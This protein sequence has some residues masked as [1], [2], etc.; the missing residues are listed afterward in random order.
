MALMAKMMRRGRVPQRGT[1]TA[2]H[3]PAP[4]GGI[5]TITAASAMPASDCLY[6]FN[7]I[8]FQYGLRV[9]SGYR[10]WAT[11]ITAAETG[12]GLVDYG[13]P[14]TFGISA[15]L[16]GPQ[17]GQWVSNN[18]LGVRTLLAFNG[19]AA[20]GSQDRLW[21]VSNTG[22]WDV[23]N[24]TAA[25][26][27]VYAFGDG[28][29]PNG[30]A[31]AGYG[32]GTS[33]VNDS[34]RHY[35]CYCDGAWGYLLYSEDSGVWN[36]ITVGNTPGQQIY[37]DPLY[38]AVYGPL[39]PANFRFVMQWKS[40]LWFV[41]E[42]STTA[43]Y[44]NIGSFT[45]EAFP[46][47]FAPRFKSGGE[48]VGLWAWTVDGGVGIDDHLVA[49]SRGGDVVIYSGT[50]P[51]I[52]GAFGLRGVWWV[53]RPPPGR[54]IASTFGGDLFI[55]SVVGC[56][57]LSKLVS[58][59]LIRDPQ[60]LASVKLANLFNKLMTARGEQ[61]GWSIAIHPTDN[62]LLITV[63]P[64]PDEPREQLSMSLAN[65]GWSQHLGV[66]MS[67]METWRNKLYFGTDDGRV[68]VNDGE[69]DDVPL[70]ASSVRPIEWALLTSY[71][72]LGNPAKKRVHMIR[73]HFMTDGTSPGYATGARFDFDLSP[74]DLSPT[75]ADATPSAWDIAIW[76]T[77]VWD[78][79]AGIAGRYEGATGM[80]SHV[81]LILRGNSVTNTTFVG[82]DVVLDSGG[83][84]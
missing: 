64:L 61:T 38:E 9:R 68:C 14:I 4:V 32:V 73:P 80:G 10:E 35:Y 19:S 41:P 13:S 11:G 29:L 16:G 40:R 3:L 82:F 31:Q 54:R 49:I 65:Q 67:C 79:G 60:I 5:N 74:L 59:G 77:S 75:A 18:P 7:M 44:L 81:A 6:L 23:T 12:L 53:G 66:P 46:M 51:S 2:V 8:P 50:D 69:V 34:G 55:L 21:A 30:P 27:K 33:F 76:D 47:P 36:A 28:G 20:D 78:D 26:V 71:Q 72:N 57:P 17:V 24:S 45:G 70:D 39:D 42:N 62:I 37:I 83:I 58:G 43:W 56:V 25:P 22:I 48:L 84:L 52:P 15:P 1:S 63:P